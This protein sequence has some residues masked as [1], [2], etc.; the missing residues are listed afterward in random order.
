MDGVVRDRFW[1]A[2]DENTRTAISRLGASHM[3]Q[4]TEH[5]IMKNCYGPINIAYWTACSHGA[6]VKH[7]RKLGV[8]GI[9]LDALGGRPQIELE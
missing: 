9:H 1:R 8:G 2:L 3:S 6:I 4:P 7:I 5:T